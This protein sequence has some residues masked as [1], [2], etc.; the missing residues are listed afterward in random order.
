MKINVRINAIYVGRNTEVKASASVVLNDVFVI[1]NVK[2]VQTEGRM[3]ASMP[4]ERKKSGEWYNIAHPIT[5]GFRAELD[6]AYI[7]AYNGYLAG[8]G[9]IE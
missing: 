5:P 1:N 8:C 2:L 9:K 3:F 7:E 4:S 6:A